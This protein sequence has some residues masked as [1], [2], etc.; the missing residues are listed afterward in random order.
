MAGSAMYESCTERGDDEYE[1]VIRAL[2]GFGDSC[3]EARL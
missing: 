1:S 3:V 2:I